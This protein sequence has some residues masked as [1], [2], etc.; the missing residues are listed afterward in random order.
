MK[1]LLLDIRD[2]PK[3]YK[4]GITVCG[5]SIYMSM[6]KT[7]F[8]E[9]RFMICPKCGRRRVKLYYHNN[10]FYCRSCI[11][12]NIYMNRTNMYDEG[13]V[14]LIMYYIVK[15]AKKLNIE[16]KDLKFPL[17][18]E[19]FLFSKPKYMRWEKFVLIVKQLIALEA[20]RW[21][22]IEGYTFTAT[23]IKENINEDFL[24]DMSMD[25]LKWLITSYAYI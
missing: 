19:D 9:K 6:Q 24:K 5:K 1:L 25:T 3:E 12:I 4:C 21:R 22:A 8:G 2:I 18:P 23:V 11:G 14:H 13:G 7:G 10:E 15:V 16:Y 17:S 20:M